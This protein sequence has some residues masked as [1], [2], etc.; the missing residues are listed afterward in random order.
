M[1]TARD[2]I[3]L[4]LKQTGVLGVGQ[5]PSAEDINDCFAILNMMLKAW[6]V[7]RYAV[8]HLVD[9][10][11]PGDG[12]ASRTIGPTGQIVTGRP[13]RIESAYVRLNPTLPQPV[14]IPVGILQAKEDYNRISVKKIVSFPSA[15]F[16]D[17]GYPNATLYMWPVPT[18]QYTVFLSVL[19]ELQ[20]FTNL[21][22]TINLP[23]VYEMALL[24][25]LCMRIAPMFGI[26]T[27][28]DVKALAKSSMDTLK[29]SATQVPRLN[30]GMRTGSYGAYSDTYGPIL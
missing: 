9:I 13:Y 21:S 6:A 15:V 22:D 19:A 11:I 26:T 23:G 29:V 12:T 30:P 18:S 2:L 24:Y 3:I 16:L 10:E 8:Y 28:E 27:P 4:A 5:A 1:T 20:T 14:D 25:N 7:S 17:T